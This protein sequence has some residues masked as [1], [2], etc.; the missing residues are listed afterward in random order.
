MYS[1]TSQNLRYVSSNNNE[2]KEVHELFQSTVL[3]NS[4]RLWS[5]RT[6]SCQCDVTAT[7][8]SN[9]GRNGLTEDIRVSFMFPYCN[10]G[11]SE[12]WLEWNVKYTDDYC[13]I[14]SRAKF[15]T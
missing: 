13:S 3:F 12:V 7:W 6:R 4:L 2:M 11:V 10:L 14:C 9:V 8:L 5:L 1:F 15:I